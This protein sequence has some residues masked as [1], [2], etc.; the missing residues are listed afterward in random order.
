MGVRRRLLRELLASLKY[1]KNLTEQQIRASLWR[2]EA[3]LYDLELEPRQL[4]QLFYD[5][6]P[7]GL[8][9]LEA[10]VKEVCI[11][12]PWRQIMTQS[13]VVVAHDIEMRAVVHCED[14]ATWREVVAGLQRNFLRTQ[15]EK[16]VSA[17]ISLLSGP[18]GAFDQMRQRIADGMQI[19]VSSCTLSLLSCHARHFPSHGIPEGRSSLA[20]V[21]RV[22]GEDIT[23]SPSDSQQMPTDKLKAMAVYIANE[24]VMRISKFMKCRSLR[25][26][27]GRTANTC[28]YA[29]TEFM[30]Q[31]VVLT[32]H[33]CQKFPSD[34]TRICPFVIGNELLWEFS[35]QLGITACE[36]QVRAVMA[37]IMDVGRLEQ[38]R[39]DQDLVKDEPAEARERTSSADKD[40][41]SESRERANSAELN[42][43]HGSPAP[44]VGGESA[45]DCGD[46]LEEDTVA[47]LV[48]RNE[49][50]PLDR[51]PHA[52]A[53]SADLTESPALDEKDDDM[54]SCASDKSPTRPFS[55]H[56]SRAD[57]S[58]CDDT[59]QKMHSEPCLGTPPM[60][61]LV[62]SRVSK[63]CSFPLEEQ[64]HQQ[65][66]GDLAEPSEEQC[67]EG[68]AEQ[69]PNTSCVSRTLARGSEAKRKCDDKPQSKRRFEGLTSAKDLGKD[70]VDLFGL[71]P[72]TVPS[73][74]PPPQLDGEPLMDT[75]AVSRTF[76]RG[77]E[78]R[79]AQLESRS[80]TQHDHR[81][82]T[83]MIA[84][85]LNWKKLW[86]RHKADWKA[87]GR[88]V[89]GGQT[90]EAA[91]RSGMD[92]T[93]D[94]SL[95]LERSPKFE[96]ARE[97]EGEVKKLTRKKKTRVSMMLKII[98]RLLQVI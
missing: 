14:E 32:C 75:S 84:D 79:R 52:S 2:G 47:E 51:V 74:N 16:V 37:T 25:V 94:Q 42:L 53:A 67:G 56:S 88:R 73:T 95:G 76:A 83:G 55:R 36:C 23:L 8:E 12:I 91:T 80:K 31:P 98:F 54:C 58:G 86:S 22:V 26:V 20:E 30:E 9:I 71:A 78:P 57:L 64:T 59:V 50:P 38:W 82:N 29:P 19:Q 41:A 44:S 6:F 11:R 70:I 15:I 65:F 24:R 46:A 90:G 96:E 13:I 43:E 72:H 34:G 97:P 93:E 27:P 3:T 39:T 21:F 33:A 68:L 69:L 17:P 81:P 35:N 10:R 89:S 1:I 77:A 87:L 5:A 40:D 62:P 85:N 45:D 63:E 7:V 66:G 49:D 48:H 4:Q 60:V 28:P 61:S 92:R 18:T